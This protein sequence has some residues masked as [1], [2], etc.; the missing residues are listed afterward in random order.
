MLQL[1]NKNL[2]EAQ[3]NR[4]GKKLLETKKVKE[5]KTEARSDDGACFH[6][7]ILITN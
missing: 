4:S 6:A 2:T 3:M 7:V 1:L 5:K